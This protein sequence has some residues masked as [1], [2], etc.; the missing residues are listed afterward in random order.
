MNLYLGRVKNYHWLY[1]STCDVP[2]TRPTIVLPQSVYFD[3]TRDMSVGGGVVL[4]TEK[5]FSSSLGDFDFNIGL[6][7]STISDKQSKVLM[8]DFSNGEPI[9]DKGLHL[10]IYWQPGLSDLACRFDDEFVIILS[11]VNSA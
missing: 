10:S 4:L 3:D 7:E 2:M 11:H 6:S 1:S 5:Y 9:H 8:G